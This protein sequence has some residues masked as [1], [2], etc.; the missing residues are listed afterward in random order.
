MCLIKKTAAQTIFLQSFLWNGL[1]DHVKE[2]L[3]LR[4][5]SPSKFSHSQTVYSTN[6]FRPALGILLDG[7]LTVNMHGSEGHGVLMRRLIAGQVF[8]A[9]ALFGNE[10]TYVSEVVA[11]T[12]CVVQFIPE[13]E[14]KQLCLDYPQIALNYIQFLSDRVRF[15]NRKIQV[16]TCNDAEQRLYLYLQSH[17]EPDGAVCLDHKMTALARQLGI[18]RSTLYRSFARLESA[19]MIINKNNTWYLKEP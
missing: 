1:E 16:F 18:G 14:L 19:G 17:T 12:D 9:A 3:L 11:K 8:G 7:V 10:K 13:N 6:C 4:F 15:L 2:S 5:F